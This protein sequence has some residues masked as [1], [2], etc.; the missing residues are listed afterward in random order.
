MSTKQCRIYSQ[1]DELAGSPDFVE[2]LNN[3]VPANADIL[4]F[5]RL[6]WS[7]ISSACCSKADIELRC[8]T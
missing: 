3:L 5:A 7:E 2:E 8:L 6:V 1:C 4:R